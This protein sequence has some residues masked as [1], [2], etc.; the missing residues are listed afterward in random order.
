MESIEF[1]NRDVMMLYV[2]PSTTL[3]VGLP[4]PAAFENTSQTWYLFHEPS[5]PTIAKFCQSHLYLKEE[6]LPKRLTQN[7]FP[8][9]ILRMLYSPLSIYDETTRKLSTPT[10]QVTVRSLRWRKRRGQYVAR[11]GTH[12]Q[13]NL[14]VDVGKLLV[15]SGVVHPQKE[16]PVI[17]SVWAS[18]RELPNGLESI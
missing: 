6:R 15:H 1:P 4:A 5:L 12:S 7:I 9:I 14:M 8:S 10:L 13:P 16:K 17:I 2:L 3:E 18:R 11:F